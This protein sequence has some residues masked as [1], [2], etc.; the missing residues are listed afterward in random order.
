MPNI[1]AF[2]TGVSLVYSANFPGSGFPSSQHGIMGGATINLVTGG[3]AMSALPD[4]VGQLNVH[5]A[6][7][8]VAWVFLVPCAVL[9][10]RHK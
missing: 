4:K 3:S 10:A 2:Q 1:Q 6:L 5:A 8:I 7:M 9:L